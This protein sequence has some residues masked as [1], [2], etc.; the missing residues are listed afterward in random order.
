MTNMYILEPLGFDVRPGDIF[1]LHGRKYQA[2]TYPYGTKKEILPGVFVDV[3]MV[4]HPDEQEYTK[5]GTLVA[6]RISD[7]RTI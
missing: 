5:P 1:D 3:G 6:R 4:V 2:I 7:I